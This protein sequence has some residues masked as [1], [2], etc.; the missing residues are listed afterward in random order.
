MKLAIFGATG[1]IG[2]HLLNWAVD[3]GHDVRALARD[4]AGLR[5]RAGLTL[6]Q[7]D[8]LDPVPVADVIS[9]ADAVLSALGPRGLDGFRKAELL[10]PAAANIIAGMYKTGAHRLLM[11]SAAGAFVTEDP[12]MPW[13][14]KQTLPRILARPFADVRHMERIVRDS[15]LDWTLVRPARLLNDP[16]RGE[17]RVR[18]DYPPQGG[19]KIARAD[20]ALF[21]HT[22]LTTTTY[23]HE[24]PAI[25]Y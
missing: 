13:F 14:V 4:P 21:I 19:A 9:G 24:S 10:A 22:A 23:I 5:P 17:Y 11:V 16:G 3:A 6:T 8:V 25:T 1:G 20:V 18:P 7:G 2:G 12:D 15:E